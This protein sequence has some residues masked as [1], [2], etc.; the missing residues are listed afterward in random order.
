MCVWGTPA[1]FTKKA[2]GFSACGL[3][4]ALLWMST[5]L[6][7]TGPAKIKEETKAER[8]GII[9]ESGGGRRVVHHS[10]LVV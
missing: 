4:F 8:I 3:K 9:Q 2:A 7:T 5:I 1:E 6:P 10:S